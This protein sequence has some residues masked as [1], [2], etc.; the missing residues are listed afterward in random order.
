MSLYESFPY[1]K[2]VLQPKVKIVPRQRMF[3]GLGKYEVSKGYHSYEDKG[4][5]NAIFIIP[6][7]TRYMYGL[8]E[9]IVSERIIFK[10]YS[11]VV[12]KCLLQK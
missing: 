11:E 4:N 9:D 7:G 8:R 10:S 2:G 1:D 12:E 5:A 3:Y 6:A